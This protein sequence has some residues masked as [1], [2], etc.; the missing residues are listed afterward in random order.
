MLYEVYTYPKD[1]AL[2]GVFMGHRVHKIIIIDHCDYTA[3][4]CD[5]PGMSWYCTTSIKHT[6]G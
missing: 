5:K 1:Q 4:V 2:M 6:P 3:P